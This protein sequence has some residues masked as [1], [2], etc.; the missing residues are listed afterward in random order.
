MQSQSNHKKF[1]IA[2]AVR[3]CPDVAPTY[4]LAIRQNTGDMVPSSFVRE[5]CCV[6]AVYQLEVR[7]R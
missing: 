3:V 6:V 7:S 2:H 5:A 4:G 1:F